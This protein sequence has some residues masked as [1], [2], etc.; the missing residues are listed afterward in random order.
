MIILKNVGFIKKLLMVKDILK[1]RKN[2]IDI[3]CIKFAGIILYRY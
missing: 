3:L 2:K 1:V